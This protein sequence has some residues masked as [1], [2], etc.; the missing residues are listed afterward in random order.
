MAVCLAASVLCADIVGWGDNLLGLRPFSILGNVIVFN[1]MA[2]A[3][4]L[5][6]LILIAVYPRVA[7][8]RMLY[9]D[10]MPELKERR[11][12]VRAAGLAILVIGRGRRL[13]D[14]QSGLHR[15]LGAAV[16]LRR[17]GPGAI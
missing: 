11:W 17:D 7:R 12:G 16:S 4:V 3:L 13:A 2:S 9:N 5:S 15:L 6:P 1:N 8:G 10:V 14:G